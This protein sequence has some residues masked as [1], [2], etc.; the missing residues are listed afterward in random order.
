MEGGGTR[1]D[2]W[3]VLDVDMPIIVR[4]L[5]SAMLSKF[6]EENVRT[7]AA[8]KRYAETYSGDRAGAKAARAA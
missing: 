3:L 5:R 1:V 7:M 4:P 2:R 8:V 6:D